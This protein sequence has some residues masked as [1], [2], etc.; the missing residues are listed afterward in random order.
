[1]YEESL[2]VGSRHMGT[3]ALKACLELTLGA[4]LIP[5]RERSNPHDSNAI[6]LLSITGTPVGYVERDIA[7]RV[8]PWMDEG[9]TVFAKVIREANM[10]N[11][12]IRMK[13]RYP[14]A[15]LWVERSHEQTH[16]RARQDAFIES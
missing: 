6:R 15:M 11:G 13:K 14:L 9:L 16:G 4:A 2:V 12:I 1:M 8:A 5:V 10:R 3:R 7:A